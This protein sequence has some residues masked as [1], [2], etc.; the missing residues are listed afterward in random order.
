MVYLD[1]K[2][3]KFEDER[4]NCCINT[5]AIAVGAKKKLNFLIDNLNDLGIEAINSKQYIKNVPVKN[6]FKL[7]TCVTNFSDSSYLNTTQIIE[8]SKDDMIYNY[9]FKLSYFHDLC[10]VGDDIGSYHAARVV[11][12]SYEYKE[13]EIEGSRAFYSLIN[14]EDASLLRGE[15]I[16]TIKNEKQ[17]FPLR[18]SAYLDDLLADK[19]EL[20]KDREFYRALDKEIIRLYYPS[21]YD[22]YNSSNCKLFYD[23]QTD[24]SDIDDNNFDNRNTRDGSFYDRVTYMDMYGRDIYYEYLKNYVSYDSYCKEKGL[25]EA[26]SIDYYDWLKVKENIKKVNIEKIESL[27]VYN[28]IKDEVIIPVYNPN[29]FRYD[30]DEEEL[31]NNKKNKC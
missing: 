13:E 7:L 11:S 26:V 5:I 18:V 12:N 30:E 15:G 22:Y 19:R 14:K 24:L 8:L 1:R 10:W 16:Y 2:N 23:F 25:R 21:F 6:G 20:L 27:P 28:E 4:L 17:W 29:K 31:I 9:E 3:I